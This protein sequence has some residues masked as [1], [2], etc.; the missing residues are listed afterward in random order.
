MITQQQIAKLLEFTGGELLVTSCYLNLDRSKMPLQ[1]LKIRTKD[2]L[3]AALR[4]LTGKAA[5]HCQRESLRADFERIELFVIE[6]MPANN[7]KGLAIFS[8]AGEKFWQTFRL[9]RLNR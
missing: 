4:D 8:C 2:L 6:H 9:P 1:M 7:H 3:Q 5:T